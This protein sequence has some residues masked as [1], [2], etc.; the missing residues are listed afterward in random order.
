MSM[1]SLNS[2]VVLLSIKAQHSTVLFVI[3]LLTGCKLVFR[4]APLGLTPVQFQLP[5]YDI[6]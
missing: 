5:T 6:S 1:S 4:L 3:Q 2:G